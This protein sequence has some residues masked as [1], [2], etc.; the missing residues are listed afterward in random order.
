MLLEAHC[1]LKLDEL[2]LQRKQQCEAADQHQPAEYSDGD[3]SAPSTQMPL[4]ENDCEPAD[5]LQRAAQ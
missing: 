1:V 2:C 5:E 4:P 3:R